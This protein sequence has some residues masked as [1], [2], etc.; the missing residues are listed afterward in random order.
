MTI[1]NPSMEFS[2]ILGNTNTITMISVNMIRLQCTYWAIAI[3][4]TNVAVGMK[5][6]L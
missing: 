5:T 6:V 2:T 3:G 1:N 4:K